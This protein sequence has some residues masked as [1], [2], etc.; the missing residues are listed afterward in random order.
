VAGGRDAIRQALAGFLALRQKFSMH[1]TKVVAAGDDL[2]VV[3]NDWTLDGRGPN[4]EPITM[5]GKAIEVVRRQ[6]DGTWLF[7]VDDPFARG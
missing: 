1:V 4:Q 5:S 6:R 3:Y 2:A 7:V